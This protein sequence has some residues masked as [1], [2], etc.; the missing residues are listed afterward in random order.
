MLITS[1][2]NFL[3]NLPLPRV[4]GPLGFPWVP[5]GS[6]G[7]LVLA[8]S[9]SFLQHLSAFFTSSHW[10][11][12]MASL[13]CGCDSEEIF[14]A[15]GM[16]SEREVIPSGKHTK[17]YGK[18][19]FLI[20]KSTINGLFNGKIHYLTMAIFNSKLLVHQRVCNELTVLF[21][22]PNQV[23]MLWEPTSWMM[24]NWC[25][26]VNVKRSWK[27]NKWLT[28]TGGHFTSSQISVY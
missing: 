10:N 17:N 11:A 26:V 27:K 7:S 5:L 6:L 18:S 21:V 28:M 9:R 12:P 13:F 19:P 1:P 16:T 24:S 2:H 23:G 25:N 20:G 22:L 4:L 8:K 14:V 15:C 3:V